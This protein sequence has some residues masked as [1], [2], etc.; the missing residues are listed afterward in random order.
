MANVQADGFEP[1]FDKAIEISHPELDERVRHY[2]C[3][4][5]TNVF[6]ILT[7]RYVVIV[8]AGPRPDH[9]R[10]IHATLEPELGSRQ[11]LIINNQASGKYCWG[12]STFVDL[13][14]EKAPTIIGHADVR[15]WM[16]DSYQVERLQAE[17]AKDSKLAEIRI[18]PPS[19]TYTDSLVI[20]GGD[21][22]LDL[23]HTPGGGF[24]HT[25]I[26]IPQLRLLL[27]GD[28]AHDPLPYAHDEDD[29]LDLHSSLERILALRPEKVLTSSGGEYGPELLTQNLTTLAAVERHVQRALNRGAIPDPLSD[30]H[31]SELGDIIDYT[32]YQ[33]MADIGE[34]YGDNVWP[35]CSMIYEELF[36]NFLLEATVE[37]LRARAHG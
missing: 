2:R 23:L 37:L 27:S 33:A 17:Q 24:G 16:C 20:D 9:A 12:N 30:A 18:I 34:V 21:L 13:E 26:W 11:A 19:I 15:E 8:G 29:L 10:L 25:A 4:W 36:Y 7:Q 1:D 5:S 35:S 31:D 3:L 28:V 32:F 6:A 22:T 14:G